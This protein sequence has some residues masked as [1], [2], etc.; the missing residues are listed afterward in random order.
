MHPYYPP[1][2]F[3]APPPPPRRLLVE[4]IVLDEQ[5][6]ASRRLDPRPWGVRPWLFP[7]LALIALVVIANVIG[8]A[9]FGNRHGGART[10][11]GIA[12]TFVA[13]LVLFLLLLAIGQPLARRGGGWRR[14]FGLDRVRRT[15]W[16]PWL[17]GVGFVFVGRIAVGFLAY[18]LSDG[19]ALTQ[20]N[21][22]RL[23]S[24][25]LAE[26]VVLAVP[27][28]IVA[29]VAEELMFRGLILR[30]FMRRMPFWPAAVLSTFLFGLAH[31]YEVATVAGAAT[32]AAT[33]G[34]L[35]IVNCYLVRIT[36]RLAPGMMLHATGNGVAV[37]YLAVHA[38]H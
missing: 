1:P 27:L 14:T 4:R 22:V 23:P 17:L 38:A 20:A 34:V 21:N 32:L 33:V 37:L 7:L 15:D 18:V 12:L 6:T 2:P 24:A 25:T 16:L 30:T 13:E 3:A 5:M 10:W 29:P 28:V 35:G 11:G 36:G 19:S 8:V 9:A 31:T 26:V